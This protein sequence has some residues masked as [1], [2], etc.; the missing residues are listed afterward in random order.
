MTA[1]YASGTFY[2]LSTHSHAHEGTF[3]IPIYD[4]KKISPRY[5]ANKKQAPGLKTGINLN[6]FF[7][8]KHMENMENS[9]YFIII[10]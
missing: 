6:L 3:I 9:P 5:Q 10:S 1:G 2:A 4:Y 7:Y 8:A